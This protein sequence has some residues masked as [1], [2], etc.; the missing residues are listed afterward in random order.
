MGGAS[1][2]G[3][4]GLSGTP[5]GPQMIWGLA[6]ILPSERPLIERAEEQ[7]CGPSPLAIAIAFGPQARPEVRLDAGSIAGTRDRLTPFF[8]P[9]EHNRRSRRTGERHGARYVR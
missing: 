6:L 7:L 2:G 4:G 9:F 8:S 5:W 3:L 1:A